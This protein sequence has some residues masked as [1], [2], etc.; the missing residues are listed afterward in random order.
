M[1]KRVMFLLII[2]GS[3]LN[4]CPLWAAD[5][6]ASPKEQIQQLREQAKTDK[7]ANK[8]E[9]KKDIQAAQQERAEFRKQL[10]GLRQQRLSA[11]K[12]GNTDEAKKVSEQIKQLL[13]AQRQKMQTNRSEI[14]QDKKEIKQDHKEL[15]EKIKAVKAEAKENK[16]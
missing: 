6:A 5:T 3:F 13:E 7:I 15:K 2:T 1:K 4:F 11:I 10:D 9:L 14:K 8:Q 12:S 16:K